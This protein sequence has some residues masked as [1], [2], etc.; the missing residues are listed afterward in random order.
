MTRRRAIWLLSSELGIKYEDEFLEAPTPY[1]VAELV[2]KILSDAFARAAKMAIYKTVVSNRARR[3]L[4][5][6]WPQHFGNATDYGIGQ[7]DPVNNIIELL[8]GIGDILEL[9]RGYIMPSSL[10]IVS[11][12]ERPLIICGFPICTFAQEFNANVEF[13][14]MTRRFLGEVAATAVHQWSFPHWLGNPPASTKDWTRN[15]ID[16]LKTLFKPSTQQ[17]DDIDVYLPRPNDRQPQYFRWQRIN[18]ARVEFGCSYLFRIAGYGTSYFLGVVE[19]NGA[20]V[21][22][23]FETPIPRADVLRMQ[24]GLDAIEKA[25]NN[26]TVD[27]KKTRTIVELRNWLPDAELR[28]VMALGVDMSRQQGRLPSRFRF[29]TSDWP[30]VQT[31]LRAL[32]ITFTEIR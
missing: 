18:R 23:A 3:V 11:L 28:L 7:D 24:Y 17:A 14:G 1:L 29:A 22:V 6:L 4:G 5:A 9:G 21:S 8:A 12:H 2:R 16:A 10:R 20:S 27:Q 31:A 30:T 25:I 26:C 13:E 15:R 32:G 19:Q